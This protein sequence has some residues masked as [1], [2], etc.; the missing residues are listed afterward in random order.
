MI[1][2]VNKNIFWDLECLKPS[3]RWKCR[4]FLSTLY[5]K[6]LIQ[7]KRDKTIETAE[8]GLTPSR[9]SCEISRQIYGRDSWPKIV[10]ALK[11]LGAISV[12]IKS[13]VGKQC[14][15]YRLLAP[16]N[17]DIRHFKLPDG[18]FL[19]KLE[20]TAE[21]LAYATVKGTGAK[22]VVESYRNSSIAAGSDE[23]LASLN[24]S[25]NSQ[26]QSQAM[27]DAVKRRD[28]SFSRC[29]AG[30]LH[31]P[32]SNLKREL[33]SLLLLDGEK[34]CEVDVSASQPT[35]HASLYGSS[36]EEREKYL[37]FATSKRFYETAAEWEGFVGPRD[38]CK[39][40]VFSKLFYGSIYAAELPENMPPMWRRFCTEF[41]VLAR[42]ME[43]QKRKGNDVLPYQMQKLESEIV[44]DTAC[45]ALKEAKIP[46]LTVHDSIIV[47]V[48]RK[49]EA[50]EIF[51]KS[52]ISKV[53]FEPKF[54][55]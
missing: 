32:V 55:P 44:I 45:Q 46:V 11:G 52:W 8:A 27:L 43:E 35:L 18:R 40:L 33:R 29:K 10:S 14:L 13:V 24:L 4:H 2:Y 49:E 41:P 28:P 42:L 1:L 22:W 16:Y 30:R 38:E 20:K 50:K 31:Y 37:N 54:K 53:G 23:F 12:G 19:Q 25:E 21:K 48:S 7:N 39:T 6:S 26:R 5:I 51:R 34:V 17:L 47:P 36:C 9:I 15:E 3:L